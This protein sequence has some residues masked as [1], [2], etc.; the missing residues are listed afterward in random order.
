M[1]DDQRPDDSVDDLVKKFAKLVAQADDIRK[2][3][4]ALSRQ[5]EAHTGKSTGMKSSSEIDVRD[6]SRN[7]PDAQAAYCRWMKGQPLNS[8]Q[9]DVT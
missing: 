6:Q 9:T 7:V 5:I 4:K 8:L 3:M 2:Q 1:T